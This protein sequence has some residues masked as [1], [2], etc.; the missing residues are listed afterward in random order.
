MNLSLAV[1]LAAL[2]SGAIDGAESER[3]DTSALRTY[4]RAHGELTFG[5][6]GQWAD[7]RTRALALQPTANDPVGAGAITEPFLGAPFNATALVGATLESRFVCDHVRLTVGV[8]F[9]FTN[10]RPSDTAQSVVIQGQAH[11]V[12][13]RS[14]DLWDLRT[15][16]GFEVPFRRVT[17]FV[18]VLGDLQTLTTQ[19][20]IDGTTAKYTGRAFSLGARAGLRYQVSHL[21]LLAAAEGTALGPRRLGGTVQMGFAF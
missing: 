3:E 17:P 2:S 1:L 16:I 20:S 18:D 11:D 10:F 15:G 13:V 6:L 21:F 14:V 7:E 4:S 12:F 8:R 19:L 5:Y 9:P